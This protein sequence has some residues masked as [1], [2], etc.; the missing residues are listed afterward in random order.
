MARNKN[1]PP[2]LLARLVDDKDSDVSN[3]ALR[4]PALP[5]KALA[6]LVKSNDYSKRRALA[7][8]QDLADKLSRTHRPD[9]RVSPAQDNAIH[10]FII[11]SKDSSD[12]GE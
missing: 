7:Y 1:C 12:P 6:N 10:L 5:D 3:A 9:G 8:R 2:G 4:N 11:E